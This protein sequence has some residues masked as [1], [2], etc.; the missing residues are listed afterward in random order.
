MRKAIPTSFRL[1]PVAAMALLLVASSACVPASG[2]TGPKRVI[3]VTLDTTR[4]DHLSAYGYDFNTS[5]WFDRM[6]AD[7]VAFGRAYSQSAT[8]KPSHASLFTSLYPTQHGVQNNGLVLD[9]DFVTMAE[10]MVDAGYRTA[11]FISADAPLG[12]NLRQG[13]EQ[14]NEPLGGYSRAVAGGSAYRPAGA[15]IDAAIAWLDDEADPDAPLFL[16]VHVYDAHSPLMPPEPY[17]QQ[18]DELEA[19]VGS[20]AHRGRL[21]SHGIGVDNPD[22]YERLLDYDAEILYA[23]TQLQRL[24]D[25]MSAEGMRDDTVW[26][27]TADHGQGLGSHGFFGHAVQIFNAQL[28]VPLVFWSSEGAFAPRRVDEALVELTDVL[29]TVL[30]MVGI[31]EMDQV[32]PIQGQ[33]LWPYL[34]DGTPQTGRGLAYSERSRY[35]DTESRRKK[36][37]YE[38]G[39]RY[40]SQDLSYKY[41]LFTEGPDEFYDL[42]TDPY[43]LVNLIDSGDH[44]E[45]RGLFRDR[46]LGLVASTQGGRTP[47]SVSAEEIARLRALGYLQ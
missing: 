26:I 18:I 11:A 34:H 21:R 39:F 46:L 9:D 3:L 24:F 7:G 8:T 25:F 5:P 41:I 6:A 29:P 47:D 28:H 1:G 42:R 40:A 30:D 33:S 19:G 15:T 14:W 17:R 2:G 13:F 38:P 35:S 44:A 45:V 16:W 22:L 12:G 23:D 37:N 32:M 27:I 20:D 10:V 31:D 43:E 4:A 36:P